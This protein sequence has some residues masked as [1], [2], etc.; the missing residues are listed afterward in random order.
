MWFTQE[1]KWGPE[2]FGFATALVVGTGLTYEFAVRMTRDWA[3]RAGVAVA[4]G[5]AF[6]LL[7]GNAAV[8]FIGSEDNPA[9]LM[10][11]G[12]LA[13]AVLGTLLARFRA[14]GM[15]LALVATAVAQVTVAIVALVAGYGF[16]GPLTV[17][18]TGLW[19]ASAWLFRKAADREGV[20][21]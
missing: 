1:V 11:F 15:A 18:F 6:I 10:Y 8:G 3:Y 21:G 9:N 5:A 4:L 19:L 14:R 2:D 17:F 16:T 7:W 20:R 13:V 12:V